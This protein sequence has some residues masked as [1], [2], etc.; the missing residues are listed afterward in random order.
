MKWEDCSLYIEYT[1]KN[2][3]RAMREIKHIH[4]QEICTCKGK[5]RWGETWQEHVNWTQTEEDYNNHGQYRCY[6]PSCWEYR[7]GKESK[8]VICNK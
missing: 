7:E 3:T 5:C 1:F 6:I 4:N 2:A 8:W